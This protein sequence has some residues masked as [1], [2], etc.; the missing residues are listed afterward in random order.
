MTGCAIDHRAFAFQVFDVFQ[1]VVIDGAHHL[2]HVASRLLSG[3]VI[4]FPL[5][6]YMT[7]STVNSERAAVAKLHYVEQAA[8]RYT[9]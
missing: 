4:L 2:R 8:R 7:M 6:N 9:F 5:V 3:L 1:E